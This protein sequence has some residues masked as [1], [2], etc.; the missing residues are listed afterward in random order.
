[1]K[2]IRKWALLAIAVPTILLAAF[3]WLHRRDQHFPS[4]MIDA[5]G[6]GTLFRYAPEQGWSNE[7]RHVFHFT[8]QGSELIPYSWFLALE[9]PHGGKLFKD[10]LSRYGFLY[11]PDRS[12]AGGLNPDGLPIGFAAHLTDQHVLNNMDES[13]WL[14]LTCAACHT[15]AIHFAAK[16]KGKRDT[17]IIIDGGATNADLGSFLRDLAMAVQTTSQ[18]KTAMH[19]FEVR[20]AAMNEMPSR[21][22]LEKRLKTYAVQLASIDHLATPTHPWGSGRVDAFGVI[23]NR[24][25]NYDLPLNKNQFVAPDAPVRYPTLWY[26]NRQ[27]HVQWHGEVLNTSW[28]RRLARNTAEVSGV[29]ARVDFTPGKPPY[30]SSIDPVGLGILD[31]AVNHL[32]PPRWPSE[33]GKL[34]PAAVSRGS[35]IFRDLSRGGCIRC[36][37][38][39]V[40]DDDTFI[41]IAPVPLSEV[42]TDDAMTMQV[43]IR[44]SDTAGLKGESQRLLGDDTGIFGPKARAGAIVDNLVT[45][46]LADEKPE[47]AQAFA[48]AQ[49]DRAVNAKP[50]FLL[51][52]GK[53]I[54]KAT[55]RD[56]AA[57][58]RQAIKSTGSEPVF[59]PRVALPAGKSERDQYGYEPRPLAGIWVAAPYLHNGSVPSLAQLLR[60]KPRVN[61]FNVGAAARMTR[62]TSGSSQT[63][64]VVFYLIR[65]F[66]EIRT[67]DMSLE[68]PSQTP[69]SKT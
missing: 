51:W 38:D 60:L 67:R 21:P 3:G 7:T 46:A 5:G 56:N 26:T 15:G 39:V 41:K 24:I 68:L 2:P 9:S 63:G 23:F 35:A 12:D 54:T 25:C 43:H 27:D 61:R 53:L 37:T 55:P 34:N 33:L 32:R 19:A 31:E 17:G 57:A 4:G 18:D 28:I 62:S 65:R 58:A 40:P 49:V 1:M 69:K 16:S 66:R 11:E 10:T 36:H 59:A 30:A 44:M 64:S 20:L 52:D 50:G 48:H 14:G 45:G 6:S 29:F 47:I 13:R 42:G 8:S 22:E